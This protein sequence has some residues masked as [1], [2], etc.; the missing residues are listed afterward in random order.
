MLLDCSAILIGLY[1]AY[2]LEKQRTSNYEFGFLRSEVLGTFIN[3]VFLVFIALY[4]VF[5]SF[6]R[7]VDPKE[8]RGNNLILISF[9]GLLVNL[10]GIF[11][12][13]G[14]GGHGH[15]H[16]DHG[17]SHGGH[18]H[19]QEHDHSHCDSKYH[20]H[21]H[22]KK[23]HESDECKVNIQDHEHPQTHSSIIP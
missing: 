20:G 8:I 13:H 21:S 6:E 10:I 4:I 3:S 18:G 12:L 11:F 2:L 22:D 15:S 23:S 1:S 16:G 14:H 7:F 5:E 17:H 19:S 9:L